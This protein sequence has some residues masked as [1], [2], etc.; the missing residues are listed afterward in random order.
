C[1]LAG[2]FYLSIQGIRMLFFIR[3]F[4]KVIAGSLLLGVAAYFWI[5][6][7]PKVLHTLYPVSAA[8]A[9]PT[10][11]CSPNAPE[12]MAS[13]SKFSLWNNASPAGQLAYI[14]ADGVVHECHYGWSGTP[15]VSSP[16]NSH[17]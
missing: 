3:L 4:I 6:D 1:Q 14:S 15:L 7:R 10:L 11:G 5:G 2:F 16:V 9:V 13:S 8:L 12:W 17:T